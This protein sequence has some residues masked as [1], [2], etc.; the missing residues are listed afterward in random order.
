MALT[1]VIRFRVAPK[2]RQRAERVVK[3]RSINRPKAESLSDFGREGFLARLE[4]EE[5][6][7]GLVKEAA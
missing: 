3:L 7:L 1:Q 6:A 5:R 4:A 2:L